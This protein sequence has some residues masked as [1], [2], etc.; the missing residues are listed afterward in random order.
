GEGGGERGGG[1]GGGGGLVRRRSALKPDGFDRAFRIY[2]G[3]ARD[4]EGGLVAGDLPFDVQPPIDPPE[5]GMPSDGRS[6]DDLQNV[7]EVVPT[8]HVRPFVDQD[9]VELVR[10]E[11]LHQRGRH[12]NH[13]RTPPEH[14]A[15]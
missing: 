8:L 2:S 6:N 13:R 15:R 1:E 11:R 14:A 5:S 12:G 3:R 10:V 7:D 9:A 4:R